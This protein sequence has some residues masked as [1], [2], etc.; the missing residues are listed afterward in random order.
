MAGNKFDFVMA[1]PN[2]FACSFKVNS[3][4]NCLFGYILLEEFWITSQS[5]ANIESVN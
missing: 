1:T 3:R 5:N 2:K 4:A